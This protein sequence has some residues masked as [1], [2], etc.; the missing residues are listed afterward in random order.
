MVKLKTQ[1]CILKLFYSDSCLSQS[2]YNLAVLGGTYSLSLWEVR[3]EINS[4]YLILAVCSPA[5]IHIIALWVAGR[6]A[7]WQHHSVHNHSCRIVIIVITRVYNKR[8]VCISYTIFIESSEVKSATHMGLHTE[9][10]AFRWL[11]SWGFFALK[12]HSSSSIQL[13]KSVRMLQFCAT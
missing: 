10:T 8:A 9:L 2:Q 7:T 12:S 6:V 4:I 3:L 11:S 13:L 5:C 1:H